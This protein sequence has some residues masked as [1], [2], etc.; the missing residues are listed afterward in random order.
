M[1]EFEIVQ[2]I[3][4][5]IKEYKLSS[6]R[7]KTSNLP[8]FPFLEPLLRDMPE[9]GLRFVFTPLSYSVGEVSH[10]Q[11]EDIQISTMQDIIKV[12]KSRRQE[13]GFKT[14]GDVAALL[15]MDQGYYS[16][17]ESGFSPLSLKH[18]LKICKMLWIDVRVEVID[19]PYPFNLF[20]KNQD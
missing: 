20:G 7:Q 10:L 13:I 6:K 18:L 4:H 14:T 1:T 17:I 5:H 16:Q 3:D 15:G 8:Q 12:I 19:N 2:F 11:G 9:L